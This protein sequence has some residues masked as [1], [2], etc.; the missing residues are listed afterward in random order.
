MGPQGRQPAT[1][2]IAAGDGPEPVDGARAWFAIHVRAKRE[3]LAAEHLRQRGYEVFL[4]CHE[5]LRRWSDRRKRVRLPLF[6]GYLFCRT[7]AQCFARV[8]TVPGVIRIVGD[9]RGPLPVPN[10]ELELI[11]RIIDAG[12]DAVPHPFVEVGERVRVVAGPLCGNDAV[13][14]RTKNTDRLILSIELL[15][16]SVAVEV[17]AEWIEISPRSLA[18]RTARLQAAGE[19]ASPAYV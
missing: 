16:R 7:T 9:G 12:L 11:R 8:V 15:R 1:A 6:A 18:D 17:Q 13:V 19:I 10:H 14:L 2:P 4:P 3:Q 5:E